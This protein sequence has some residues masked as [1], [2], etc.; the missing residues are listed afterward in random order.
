MN[1]S[2]TAM[3]QWRTN[4]QNMEEIV[5]INRA[6]LTLIGT[7]IVPDLRPHEKCP[8]VIILHGFTGNKNESMLKSISDQLLKHKIASLR[9][10]FNAH[11]ESE[12]KFEDMTVMNEIEDA[13][14][15]LRF[16]KGLNFVEKISLV[17][18]SQ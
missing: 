13:R 10:D 3:K 1:A 5:K 16:A 12:G 6:C 11:G 15:F 14:E 8:L 4:K 18:H 17:G 2:V 9:C 7:L